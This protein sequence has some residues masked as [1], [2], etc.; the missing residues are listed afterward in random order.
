MKRKIRRLRAIQRTL[1]LLISIAVLGFMVNAYVT[2]L[3]N[4]TI[5]SGGQ[6][7]PIY[8]IDPILWPTYMMIA[9]PAVSMLFNISIMTAYY[10]GVGAANMLS[11]WDSYWNYLVHVVNI[12]IMVTTSATFQ[13]VQSDPNNSVT[14]PSNLYGWV[15]SNTVANLTSE[16]SQIPVD[17]NFQCVTQV[18]FSKL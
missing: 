10:W 3:N 6:T 17:F 18:C 1:S 7:I 5:Q 14:Q 9:A 16:F 2:F 8:P 13:K 11:K 4:R 12:V 15:C